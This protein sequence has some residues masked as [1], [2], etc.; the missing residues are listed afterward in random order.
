MRVVSSLWGFDEHVG[1]AIVAAWTSGYRAP[2][3][4]GLHH[5]EEGMAHGKAEYRC[6][7]LFRL[8]HLRG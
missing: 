6:Q 4:C 1:I 3:G 2:H 8:W 5:Y 7:H